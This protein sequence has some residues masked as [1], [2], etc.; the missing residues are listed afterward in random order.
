MND[1]ENFYESLARAVEHAGN[2]NRL[3]R[4]A[5]VNFQTLSRWVNRERT[6]NLEGLIQ[7]LPFIDWPKRGIANPLIKRIESHAPVEEVKGD[8]LVRIPVLMEAGAGTAVDVFESE[9][10][11]WIEVLPRYY[12]DKVRAIEVVG[13]SMEPTIRKGA[14]I[15]VKP[16]EGDLQEGGVYLCRIPYFGLLVKRVKADGIKGL[17]LISDNEAYDPIQ[18]PFEDADGIV[19]GQVVWCWQGL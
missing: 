9:P 15:G 1:L 14:I 5:G 12:S 8:D 13:D 18:I 10:I 7:L 16:F 19:V 6:P 17:R 11:K 4:M 2:I 3:S